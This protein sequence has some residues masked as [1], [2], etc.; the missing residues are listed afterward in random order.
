[1]SEDY[2]SEDY[3]SKAQST[4]SSSGGGDGNSDDHVL[5]EGLPPQEEEEKVVVESAGDGTTAS[6]QVLHGMALLLCSLSLLLC[7][8]LVA[9]DQT[10][11][12]TILTTVGNKFGDF[13]KISWIS[14]GFLLPT[15][16]LAM[17]WGKISLIFGRKYTMITAIVLFE[18]GSLVCALANSMNMLIGGRV[19][20]GVGGGGI[21]VMVFI[22]I[23]E[24]V[25]IDKRG[26]V[27]GLVGAAF[28]IA[29]VVGPL[30]G[31]AFTSHVSWRWCFYINLP[32]GGVAL[33]FIWYFF[34]PPP[35]QGSIK[36]KLLKVDYIGTFLIAAGL[37]LVLLALTFGSTTKPWD[38]GLVIAFFVV[39]G[40]IVCVFLVYNFKFS[41]NPLIPWRVA[42]VPQVLAPCLAL[43]FMFNGFMS[44]VLY[45]ATYF[46]VV[47]NA[48]A[49]H[50]GIDLLPMI[51][52]V[53]VVSVVMGAVVSKSRLTKPFAIFGTCCAAI[54]FGLMSMLDADSPVSKRI[55]YLILP[56]VGVGSVFQSITLSAQVAAPKDQ[57]G[58]LIATAM[59]GFARALGGTIG[60]TLGQTI[61]SIIFTRGMKS[62]QLPSNV[63]PTTLLN[64]PEHIRDLPPD[65]AKE[66]IDNFVNGFQGVMYYGLGCVLA[67]FITTWF[68]TN[69]KIPKQNDTKKPENDNNNEKV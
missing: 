41:K 49:M 12:A 43:F 66:I 40:V 50:S 61:Q 53:V 6:D 39:G 52:A 46:Q 10:I 33:A 38:D 60:S 22:I 57:G 17:N 58:V 21:Q 13:G 15:A 32:I 23:S 54:G 28:G 2:K 65:I 9:L 44:A 37:V 67:G 31:G 1:M 30:V 25:T 47:H 11:V 59:I 18:A 29:S 14:S 35:P 19:L 42:K 8:F 24:I 69:K 20:A 3:K 62:V 45:L 16:V 56:G 51:V 34:N 27:Q 68:F 48:D 63:D 55:G 7:I 36:D 64:S 5:P 4:A 26:M